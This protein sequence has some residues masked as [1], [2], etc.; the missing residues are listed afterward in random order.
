MKQNK[1]QE[2]LGMNP[3][4]ASH[5]LVKDI[6]WNF[7]VKTGENT[8]HRCGNAMCR[9]TFTIEHIE[10]WLD[11]DNPIE[12]FFSLSNIS[13]S[14]ASCNFSNARKPNE[15]FDKDKQREE[16]LERKRKH[17]RDNYTTEKRRERYLKSKQA[18][19]VISFTPQ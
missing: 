6:L 15:R 2:Q 10:P 11:S 18:S 13:F 4:T 5:R 16:Y 19:K 1:K 17:F 14:H 12:L 8:C 3:S 7:I 9:S